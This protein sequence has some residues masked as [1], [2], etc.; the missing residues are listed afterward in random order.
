M[1]FCDHNPIYCA[2]CGNADVYSKVAV[3]TN[4]L[5]ILPAQ[6]YTTFKGSIYQE[7]LHG[8]PLRRLEIH[9]C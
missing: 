5:I 8:S 3:S 7:Q 4:Q 2:S 1:G 9:M 6:G